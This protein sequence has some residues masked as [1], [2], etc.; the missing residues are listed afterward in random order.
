M[1]THVGVLLFKVKLHPQFALIA[2]TALAFVSSSASSSPRKY[3][4]AKLVEGEI[5]SWCHF[6]CAPFDNPELFFCLQVDNR[7]LIASGGTGWRWAYDNTKMLGFQGKTVSVRYDESSVWMV[8]TDGKEMHLRQN[9][10]RNAFHDPVC[11]A[12][13]HRH[14]LQHLQKEPRPNNVPLQAILVPQSQ[15]SY[16]WANCV[17]DSR[18]NWDACSVWDSRGI[19]YADRECVDRQNHRAVLQSDLL[20]DPLTTTT[21]YEFHLKNGIVLADWASG[22]INGKPAANSRPPLPPQK[23]PSTQRKH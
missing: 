1:Y 9:Y 18:S 13:L 21:D 22:R 19:K 8:R 10:S 2:M 6:D 20:I 4:D 23:P 17:F 16:F 7:T 12:E 3:Q 11:S 5:Y 14:W 15:R